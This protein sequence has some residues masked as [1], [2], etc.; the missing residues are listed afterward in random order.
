[1]NTPAINAA[2]LELS[3]ALPIGV[4]L[5]VIV[6]R[7]ADEDGQRKVHVCD[8]NMDADAFMVAANCLTAMGES[9]G[10]SPAGARLI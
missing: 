9:D 5:A 4:G 6:V 8:H 7:G 2:L 1:M 3:E 10:E